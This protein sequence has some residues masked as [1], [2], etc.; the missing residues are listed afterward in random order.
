MNASREGD[1]VGM[2]TA[3]LPDRLD[4]DLVRRQHLAVEAWWAEL[5]RRVEA[6]ASGGDAGDGLELRGWL[7]TRA[8]VDACLA[9]R[10]HQGGTRGLPVGGRA[11]AVVAH[12]LPSFGR[13][14]E[15][16]LAARGVQVIG[17][18]RDGAVAVAMTVVE[19]PDLLVLDDDL[20][21]LSTAE[22]L[23][24]VRRFAPR[25]TVL[26]RVDQDPDAAPCAGAV[27]TSGVP[28]VSREV[29][30]DAVGELC[31]ALLSPALRGAAAAG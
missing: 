26:L 21:W 3:A 2:T 19:Q 22:V 29:A 14:L 8:A 31:A 17:S 25:T 23:T 30:P 18:G 7:R 28:L 15:A 6:A 4:A 12:R 27:G 24:S 5:G 16:A 20:P 1:D 10:S 9:R 13:D 11:R